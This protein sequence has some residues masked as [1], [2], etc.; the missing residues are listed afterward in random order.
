MAQ[1]DDGLEFSLKK[2]GLSG[3]RRRLR[4]HVFSQ[5]LRVITQISE[6]KPC[7]IFNASH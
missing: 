5:S 4:L 6:Q 3:G 2:V 7:H 1:V